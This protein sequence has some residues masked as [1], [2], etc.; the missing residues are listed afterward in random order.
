VAVVLVVLTLSAC[1]PRNESKV[2]NG[3]DQRITVLKEGADGIRRGAV[4][5][6]GPGQGNIVAIGVPDQKAAPGMC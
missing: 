1:Q 3:T 5:E 6:L 4:S 2:R